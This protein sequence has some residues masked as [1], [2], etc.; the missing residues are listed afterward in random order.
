LPFTF[1]ANHDR[2]EVIEAAFI[3]KG[4]TGEVMTERSRWRGL[5]ESLGAKSTLDRCN[6]VVEGE[7]CCD[8]GSGEDAR[9]H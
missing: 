2:S 6:A 3:M 4:V 9:G 1:D 8:V 5:P 7:E